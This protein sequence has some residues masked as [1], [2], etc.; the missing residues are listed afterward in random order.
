MGSMVAREQITG[1]GAKEAGEEAEN[2]RSRVLAERLR[3]A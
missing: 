3:L 1:D 2:P